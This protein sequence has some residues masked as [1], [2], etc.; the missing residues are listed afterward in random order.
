MY[1]TTKQNEYIWLKMLKIKRVQIKNSTAN[2][3]FDDK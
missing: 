2:M 1:D 3:H